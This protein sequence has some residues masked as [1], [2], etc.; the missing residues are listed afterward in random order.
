MNKPRIGTQRALSTVVT[1]AMLIS[2]VAVMGIAL[3]GWSQSTLTNQQVVLANQ[4]Y[5]KEDTGYSWSTG[6]TIN[7]VVTT[8]RDKVYTTHVVAP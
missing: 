6:E 8:A 3:V 1:S 2:A 7:I 5:S 4:F